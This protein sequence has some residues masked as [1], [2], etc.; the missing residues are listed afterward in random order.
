MRKKG[1]LDFSYS[2]LKTAVRQHLQREG[3]PEGQAEIIIA[4]NNFHG[5]TMGIIGFSTDPVARTG[6]GPFAPGFRAV[7]FGDIAAFE[8]ALNA[9]TVAT[10]VGLTPW[11]VRHLHRASKLC[12]RAVD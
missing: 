8:A 10:I 5:R 11:G 3:V 12:T 1:V 4:S 7:K 6:F 9:N 2:G